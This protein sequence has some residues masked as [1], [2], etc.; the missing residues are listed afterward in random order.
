MESQQQPA[1]QSLQS[2]G[3]VYG[4]AFVN[5]FVH[6]QLQQLAEVQWKIELSAKLAAILEKLRERFAK[7][8]N[9]CLCQTWVGADGCDAAF[10]NN[11]EVTLWADPRL[12]IVLDPLFQDLRV[13][14]C[15]GPVFFRNSMPGKVWRSGA[16]Q[17]V[18][19]LRILPPSL[20]PR[21]QL[22]EEAL[23]RLAEALYI[24]IYDLSRPARGQICVLEVLLSTRATEAMLV[25]DVI[26]FIGNLLTALHL[27]LANPV[28]QPVRR[29]VLSGR[30]ARAPDSDGEASDDE[31]SPSGR[32]SEQQ[33]QQQGGAPNRNAEADA[34][35]RDPRQGHGQPCT[36]SR[37]PGAGDAAAAAGGSG[38]SPGTG[39]TAAGGGMC[40]RE[41]AAGARSHSGEALGN[42]AAGAAPGGSAAG[43]VATAGVARCG[44]GG[45]EAAPACSEQP[46]LPASPSHERV[47][48]LGDAA[49]VSA[50][51]HAA[52]AGAAGAQRQTCGSGSGSGRSC[53]AG[54]V[55]RKVR[56]LLDGPMQRS[57]SVASVMALSHGMPDSD[58]EGGGGGGGQ[59][60]APP[61]GG[62]ATGMGEGAS[63]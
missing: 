35:P 46:T 13:K 25:A 50:P 30:R 3:L 4:G 60:L 23:E 11:L 12:A 54:P 57:K 1:Q 63:K 36:R 53:L 39:G 6:P 55:P 29:S 24:P 43:A 61:K 41:A 14:S 40:A 48:R 5:H 38:A 34:G 27:S 58:D 44:R 22:S 9:V 32:P 2:A 52:G 45:Q 31:A 56:K 15:Q 16:V 26:S 7:S 19:N 28:Q 51:G 10:P 18:Q 17:I 33:Q 62:V 49:N 47:A 42:G 8:Q 21:S 59:D 37:E 20:H